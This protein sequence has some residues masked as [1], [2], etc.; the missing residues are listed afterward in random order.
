[1]G[2]FVVCL[3][4]R[5]LD[6]RRPAACLFHPAR[7]AGRI[8]KHS[9][10]AVGENGPRSAFKLESFASNVNALITFVFDITLRTYFKLNS[11][12]SENILETSAVFR[13]RSWPLKGFNINKKKLDRLNQTRRI[14]CYWQVAA[15]QNRE[16]SRVSRR[17]YTLSGAEAGLNSWKVTIADAT[18]ASCSSGTGAASSLG[19]RYSLFFFERGGKRRT[20]SAPLFRSE[21]KR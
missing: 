4:I 7:D 21:N 1:M 15:N 17:D 3:A 19:G 18:A 6:S 12:V 8:K 9:A 16:D 14:T 13:M 2:P 20:I 10:Q 11:Y 5:H